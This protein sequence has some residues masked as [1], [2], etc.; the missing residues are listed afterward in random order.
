MR[1][2]STKLEFVNTEMSSSSVARV[3]KET[4]LVELDHLVGQLLAVNETLVHQLAS[5]TGTSSSTR[6]RSKST[7]KSS[8]TTTTTKKKKFA[9]KSSLVPRAASISTASTDAKVAATEERRR[10]RSAE[11]KRNG[12]GAA[13]AAMNADR[14]L[15]MHEMY[16]SLA[17]TITG[18]K[19]G[20]KTKSGRSSS[21]S[22]ASGRSVSSLGGGSA[23]TRPKTRI[24]GRKLG[25]S[26]GST[27]G[28]ILGIHHIEVP[29]GQP[30]KKLDD[31][32]SK[33]NISSHMESMEVSTPQ[34]RAQASAELQGVISSLEDEFNSLNAQYQQLL[35]AA[36]NVGGHGTESQSRELVSVIQKLHKK[37]EQLRALKS[38]TK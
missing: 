34:S 33:Y 9:K 19:M 27:S 15:G 1:T 14:L 7:L 30:I 8:S 38:P 23:S 6:G 12:T 3:E 32:E 13:E 10:S 26:T 17:S 21:A 4:K 35:S 25:E 5:S 24:K 22:V 28:G 2:L 31:F 20:A 29:Y 18:K 37:G 16:V 11:N 36:D